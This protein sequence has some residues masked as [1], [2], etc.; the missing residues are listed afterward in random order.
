MSKKL[1]RLFA[2]I[3]I[4]L[5]FASP[6]KAETH[7][8]TDKDGT[9]IV[10]D[11]PRPE[12]P[13]Q[14]KKKQQA[15]VIKTKPVQKEASTGNIQE[16]RWALIQKL[17]SEGIFQKVGVPAS[18]PHLWVKPVFYTLDFDVKE[19][20]VNVVYAYYKTLSPAYDIVV[21][22]DGRTGKEIGKY[23]EIYGGLKLD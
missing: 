20:F 12:T 19:K 22:Y 3:F 14:Q 16:K 10:G 2:T 4:I 6:L 15:E 13:Q 23:S 17:I 5:A 7:S 1:W 8:Y 9:L 18:L 21:I 11:K